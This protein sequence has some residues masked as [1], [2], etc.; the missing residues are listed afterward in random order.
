MDNEG[1]KASSII[2]AQ[3]KAVGG[4]VKRCTKGKNCSATCIDP[5]E[6]CLVDLPTPVQ[7]SLSKISSALKT[8]VLSDAQPSSTLTKVSG[9]VPNTD[10]WEDAVNGDL[11]KLSKETNDWVKKHGFDEKQEGHDSNH[12]MAHSFFG[13][14][15]DY[16]ASISGG[17]RGDVSLAEEG[18]VHY[19]EQLARARRLAQGSSSEEI[20][21]YHNEWKKHGTY[22]SPKD[23]T[24]G[25]I[26]PK[27]ANKPLSKT[28]I[29]QHVLGQMKDLNLYFKLG[30]D[31]KRMEDAAD[32]V[33]DII[34]NGQSN[35]KFYNMVDS[36]P[37]IS[38]QEG[39]DFF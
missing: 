8:K 32:K 15:S 6:T 13:I 4:S 39:A 29:K 24:E 3:R 21:K 10:V 22:Y 35:P 38:E 30:N 19:L 2:S 37:K 14:N 17:K 25:T 1:P 11:A 31:S 12:V 27:F 16:L 18:L 36:L 23:I 28:D 7:G 26:S 33:S 9:Y 20:D 34:F 5:R